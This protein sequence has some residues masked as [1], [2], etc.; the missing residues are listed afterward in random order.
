MRRVGRWDF[1]R[2]GN[3][4]LLD[5]GFRIQ[6]HS[7]SRFSSESWFSLFQYEIFSILVGISYASSWESTTLWLWACLSQVF[8]SRDGRESLEFFSALFSQTSLKTCLSHALFPTVSRHGPRKINA[9]ERLIKSTV[10]LCPYNTSWS[11]IHSFKTL[12]LFLWLPSADVFRAIR[13]IVGCSRWIYTGGSRKM[14]L[15]DTCIP[16]INHVSKIHTVK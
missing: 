15:F 6:I 3:W 2:V 9:Q 5:L 10:F 12:V 8:Q 13:R 14:V 11:I 7:W 16:F 4:L 1:L